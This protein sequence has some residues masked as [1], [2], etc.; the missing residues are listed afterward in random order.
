MPSAQVGVEL[1]PSHPQ[2]FSYLQLPVYDMPEQDI[3]AF[4]PA[5]FKFIDA[6]MQGGTHLLAYA[7][8]VLLMCTP[9]RYRVCSQQMGQMFC[10][11]NHTSR[12]SAL[13]LQPLHWSMATNS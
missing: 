11:A 8:G 6:G 9:M 10:R 5:A 2:H 7:A 4:F 13:P 12:Q 3:V 1:E